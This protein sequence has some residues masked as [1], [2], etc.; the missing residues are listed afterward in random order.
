V[1][2]PPIGSERSPDRHC[3]DSSHTRRDS[4]RTARC[5]GTHHRS[6]LRS[7][8]P[9]D[10]HL[11]LIDKPTVAD[12]VPARSRP[13][14][15]HRREALHPPIDG[16]VIPRSATRSAD[17][18]I[19]QCNCPGCLHPVHTRS[20][21]RRHLCWG[22]RR[23]RSRHI[24]GDRERQLSEHPQDVVHGRFH[25]LRLRR[26]RNIGRPVPL[27]ATLRAAVTSAGAT[28]LETADLELGAPV[29][30]Y[31]SPYATKALLVLQ[32]SKPSRSTMFRA[33]S[34]R[35]AGTSTVSSWVRAPRAES[36]ML[37]SRDDLR[38]GRLLAPQ[39][40]GT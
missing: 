12:C 2:P 29:P 40:I 4:S 26:R 23:F 17:Q 28:V 30:T 37:T 13:V 11:G 16:H 33:S 1:L 15:Q 35:P 36:F 18:P 27:A 21:E 6:S 31:P 3:A 19:S 38:F 24:G 34:P 9:C 20:L 39:P 7:P 14:N 5:G 25:D 10:H 8:S 32:P 22:D